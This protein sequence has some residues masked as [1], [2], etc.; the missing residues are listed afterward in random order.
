MENEILVIGVGGAGVK[1]VDMMEV[2]KNEIVE[3]FL[4]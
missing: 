1:A 3:V 4:G 2:I